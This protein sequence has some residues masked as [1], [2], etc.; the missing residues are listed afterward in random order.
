MISVKFA[1]DDGN[2]EGAVDAGGP[3]REFLRLLVKAANEQSGLFYGKVDQRV[4]F[5]NAAGI[6]LRTVIKQLKTKKIRKKVPQNS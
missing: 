6:R 1:D 5:P 2:S 3:R 4:L